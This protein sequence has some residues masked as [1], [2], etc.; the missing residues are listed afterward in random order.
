MTEICFIHENKFLLE[1]NEKKYIM[2]IDLCL[3]DINQI[4]GGDKNENDYE[5]LLWQRGTSV[6]VP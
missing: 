6:K 5:Y 4:E 1:G 3:Y 2:K